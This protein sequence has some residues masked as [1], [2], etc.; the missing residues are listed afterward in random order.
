MDPQDL[1]NVV[2][3]SLTAV[4]SVGLVR[5]HFSQRRHEDDL[6]RAFADELAAKE[7][8]DP[9]GWGRGYTVERRGRGTLRFR[10]DVYTAGTLKSGIVDVWRVCVGGAGR[11]FCLLGRPSIA[12]ESA[13]KDL[14]RRA[15][16]SLLAASE[17][18]SSAFELLLHDDVTAALARL[19]SR[20]PV[21]T[22]EVHEDGVL[23]VRVERVKATVRELEACL[24]DVDELAAVLAR[25]SVDE[26][27]ALSSERPV[28]LGSVGPSTGDPVPVRPT[29]SSDDEPVLTSAHRRDRAR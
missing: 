9:S 6:L 1:G 3:L 10:P 24:R 11:R 15:L 4:A 2:L 18:R 7:C 27:A 17:L 5:T 22:L 23:E 26:P 8:G 21:R 19:L 25:N 14:E 28:R 20:W 13:R 16:S 29:A 12:G